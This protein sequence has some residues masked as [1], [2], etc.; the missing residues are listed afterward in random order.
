MA[1]F[2]SDEA[3]ANF[4]EASAAEKKLACKGDF[5]A[6][7]SALDAKELNFFNQAFAEWSINGHGKLRASEFRPFLNQVGIKLS[8]AQSR[9]LWDEFV[10]GL[11]CEGVPSKDGR[12]LTYDEA[13]RAYVQVSAGPVQFRLP[14]E[15]S[16]HLRAGD[17]AHGQP[18]RGRNCQVC[19]HGARG[20]TA[21]LGLSMDEARELLLSEGVAAEQAQEFLGAFLRQGVVPQA[22]LFDYFAHLS[23]ALGEEVVKA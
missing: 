23:G 1:L 14:D 19:L 20:E 15:D 16:G 9:G 8:A 13:L 12:R 6:A 18:D 10:S 5:N 22:A 7:S 2:W 21:P 4:Y 3:Y 17:A 11:P